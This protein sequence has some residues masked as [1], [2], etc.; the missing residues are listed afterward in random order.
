MEQKIW[1]KNFEIKKVDYQLLVEAYESFYIFQ[2]HITDKKYLK[3]AIGIIKNGNN[4]GTYFVKNELRVL[5]EKVIEEI[6][7][8]PVRLYKLHLK[9]IKYNKQYFIE[10]KKTDALKLEKIKTVQL[11]KKYNNLF[12]WLQLSH[13]HS[14]PTTWFV[15]SD[16]EDLSK[17]LMGYL[18]EKIKEKKSNISVAEAFSI[19]TTPK[20]DSFA[21]K[22]EI[23]MLK[24]LSLIK[25]NKS[26]KNL[27]LKTPAG[28]IKDKL[29]EFTPKIKKTIL[30]HFN[31][32]KWT[33]YDYIG[34]AYTIDFYL[35][36]WSA[37][38]RQK[39]DPEKE[40]RRYVKVAKETTEKK[41][42]IIKD[43]K[44]DKKYRDIFNLAA[45]IVWL[46]GYRK[47]VLYHGCYVTDK[48][49]KELGKRAGLTLMQM[50][51][52]SHS[53]MKN[54]SQFKASEID[55]RYRNS[56]VYARQGKIHIYVGKKAKDFLKKQI[57]EKEKISNVQELKGT[58]AC[59]GHVKGKVKLVS[60]PG[61]MSKMEKNDIMVSH[62]TFPSL[63]PAMKKAAAIVTDD[64][65]ITCHAAIV[66]RELKKPC[67]VG[68]KIA[69]KI[70]KDGDLVDVDADKGII[71]LINK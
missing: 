46:K 11:I 3:E 51:Y 61:E 1:R 60:E 71:K 29:S 53:E 56:L 15:D 30:N 45:Q 28:K 17:N 38:V 63:V 10:A 32:W 41:R 48:I 26:A 8:N 55:E 64:G 39:A 62:T 65:G 25:S 40:M 66:S 43:L 14:Q 13:G 7:R 52:I 5:I 57:I 44:I 59:V 20:W 36:A 68:T 9:T 6:M 58:C 50:K 54:F 35:E 19:L 24:V 70:F 2:E 16:G 33:P 12:H 23:E 4:D 18:E 42:K 34:P 31:K 37:L 49:L 21:K 47:D 67:I 27:F 22:E 69:T